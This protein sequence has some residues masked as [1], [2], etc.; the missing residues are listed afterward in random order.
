MR[1][2]A[3]A[4]RARL[5]LCILYANVAVSVTLTITGVS[6]S[7]QMYEQRAL[8]H[9][10]NCPTLV[11]FR[12]QIGWKRECLDEPVSLPRLQ[13]NRHRTVSARPN[14]K[15]VD[16]IIFFFFLLLSDFLL[17]ICWFFFSLSA[18]SF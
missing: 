16:S 6:V 18:F 13:F 2:S 3:H 7:A 10:T 9:T 15:I 17:L 12:F 5:C 11:A 4:I 14:K 1:S 8:S